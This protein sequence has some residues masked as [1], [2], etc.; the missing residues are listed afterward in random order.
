MKPADRRTSKSSFLDPHVDRLKTYRS[1]LG[2]LAAEIWAFD[3][4][5]VIRIETVAIAGTLSEI[6]GFG[7]LIG[8]LSRLE[9]GG[10]VWSGPATLPPEI[11]AGAALAL[12]FLLIGP[13]ALLKARSAILR[14]ATDFQLHRFRQ[15]LILANR[16]VRS[17]RPQARAF[18]LDD[19]FR[20]I[21][22]RDAR[23]SNIC[24][25]HLL[26]LPFPMVIALV[27]SAVLFVI[28]PLLTGLIMALLLAVAIS[29]YGV[30]RR[31]SRHSREMERLLP[32]VGRQRAALLRR[33]RRGEGPGDERDPW[34]AE[35]TSSGP[36][37]QLGTTYVARL[38]STEVSHFINR[39]AA[40]VALVG[41]LAV[42]LVRVFAG[43][44]T[45]SG[46][47]AYILILRFVLDSI[48]EASGTVTT[49]NRFYPSLARFDTLLRLAD[50]A[51]RERVPRPLPPLR[52]IGPRLD[53]EGTEDLVPFGPGAPLVI[54]GGGA[55]D[56]RLI[57]VLEEAVGASSAKRA[58]L[59]LACLVPVDQGEG[60][61]PLRLLCGFP[62][63]Y[64]LARLGDELGEENLAALRAAGFTDLDT[65]VEAIQWADLDP[66]FRTRL[67]LLAAAAA[68]A[69]LTILQDGALRRL[70]PA[71]ERRLEGLIEARHVAFVAS[72]PRDL[73]AAYGF[74][75]RSAVL[76]REGAVTGTAPLAWLMEHPDR[77]GSSRKSHETTDVDVDDEEESES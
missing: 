49:V 33:A 28:E 12:V 21:T 60:A 8:G 42:L 61:G 65:G 43:T 37:A 76:V 57:S 6:L 16:L 30:G 27:G 4:H 41:V 59:A 66:R 56:R 24:T 69:P 31:A 15:G 55:F 72:Q 47:F 34:L 44:L 62:D 54:A 35:A 11:I 67:R 23:A 3:R 20:R 14:F 18:V 1:V 52:L 5:R 17:P 13:L 25:R 71:L 19:D 48:R 58:A 29:L 70:D 10:A 46:L 73:E 51:P 63:D 36:E 22:S 53:G 40:F 26:S 32:S 38:R 74:R 77:L 45:L 75:A 2:R 39:V 50:S 9:A 68:A 7:L 64:D